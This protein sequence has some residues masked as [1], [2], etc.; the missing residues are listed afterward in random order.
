MENNV[1]IKAKKNV[2]LHLVEEFERIAAYVLIIIVSIIIAVSIYRVSITVVNALFIG[3]EDPLSYVFFQKTFGQIMTVLIAI[4]FNHTIIQIARKIENA[5]QIKV[6]L[7]VAMLAL[8]R[9]F[10]ILDLA[11]ITP[12]QMFALAA[13]MLS[14]GVVY[15]IVSLHKT[16]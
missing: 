15:W 8:S 16:P 4:E 1:E 9:K 13:I 11:K 10:I 3:K 2:G 6:V 7:L 14:L 5:I 12:P